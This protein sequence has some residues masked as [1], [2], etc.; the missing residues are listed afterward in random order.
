MIVMWSQDESQRQGESAAMRAT[1]NQ[2]AV[3][4]A[5]LGVAKEDYNDTAKL[6]EQQEPTSADQLKG[7]AAQNFKDTLLAR[8]KWNR[9][10]CRIQIGKVTQ[11]K[12]TMSLW[13]CLC[14][15]EQLEHSPASSS[16]CS[17][18][19]HELWSLSPSNETHILN[20]SEACEVPFEVSPHSWNKTEQTS[21]SLRPLSIPSVH[22]LM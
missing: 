12:V 4:N 19:S 21:V 17:S 16:P 8:G 18:P 7:I 5:M 1:D 11:S 22:S 13:A 20:E 10:T 3:F 14:H 6:V 9:E 2:L 15:Q